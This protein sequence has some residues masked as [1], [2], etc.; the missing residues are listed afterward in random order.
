MGKIVVPKGH[1]I[2]HSKGGFQISPY[3]QE[4]ACYVGQ[5]SVFEGGSEMLSKIA[6]IK[7]NAKQIE[8]V[9]H[10]YGE[11]IEQALER[12]IEQNIPPEI[13]DTDSPAYCMMDG[14]MVLTRE[15]SWKE[16]KLARIFRATDLTEL[17]PKRN[18][19]TNSLYVAHLGDHKDFCRKV[20]HYTDELKNPVFVGD[21]AHWIW[22][23]VNAFYPES[24]QILDFF[25]AKEHLCTFGNLYFKDEQ[26][27]KE[28]I[29][30]Q[31]DLLLT[32]NVDQV[33]EGIIQLPE[34]TNSP[35]EKS[36]KNLIEYYRNNRQRML[37]MTFRKE[38]FLIGSGPIESA[39]RN[40]VQQRMKLSG[41]RWTKKGLQQIA[42]LRAAYHSKADEAVKKLILDYAV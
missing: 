21:G 30:I 18:W 33:I 37:Y 7:M 16:I 36:R 26:I 29:Q 34:I 1:A 5:E 17:H 10:F 24:V 22:N 42:N 3:L 35:A 23:W 25:H 40:I 8:R 31:T 6:G 15:E 12:S 11:E 9:C 4:I 19:I 28:W 27:K 20:G 13:T 32:D 14:G 41:Q 38:G 39:I 2:L